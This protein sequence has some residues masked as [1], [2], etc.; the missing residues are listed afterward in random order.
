MWSRKELSSLAEVSLCNK[1]INR[2]LQGKQS[3][4]KD[5][6]RSED[7]I[8]INLMKVFES[9]R[10]IQLL[11]R[12]GHCCWFLYF[13]FRELQLYFSNFSQVHTV[14]L[15]FTTI[16]YNIMQ[17]NLI[18]IKSLMYLKILSLIMWHLLAYVC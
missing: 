6:S 3:L 9:E 12:L 13:P 11:R 2:K 8:K 5:R 16:E 14:A 18:L 7:I 17:Y 10:W 4:R 1:K 15:R